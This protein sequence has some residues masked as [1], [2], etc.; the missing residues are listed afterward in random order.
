MNQVV[1]ANGLPA[2][3]GLYSPQN[4]HDACGIGFLVNIDGKASHDIITRGIQ[5]LINLTHRG[6]CGCDPETGDGAGILIQI[7]DKFFRRETARLGFEL[8]PVG[9]YGVGMVFL[10]V[11]PQQR[12]ICE[13]ILE[14]VAAEEGLAVLGW[15]DTPV[16]RDAVGRIARASQPY[17]EQVFLRCDPCVDR[18][19]FE[20][21]LYVVLKR[22]ENEV[23]KSPDIRDK[24]FFY[25]P[26]MSSRTIVYKGLLLAP[27]IANCYTELSDPDTASALA[28]V[29]QRFSTNTFPTWQL[30]HPF[31]MVCHNGEINTV[32]G[33]TNWT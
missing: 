7:P 10:P 16:Q 14:R 32:R 24:S 26:S 5:I 19:D 28:L 17:I 9:E 1:S 22:V 30:A 20:R 2:E 21:R 18:E 23:A 31:R 25:I 11:E 13:G 33:N 12:L 8:P 3:Q 6:A 29:H 4:E 15:R 27:Q